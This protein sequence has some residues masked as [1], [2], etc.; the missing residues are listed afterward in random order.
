MILE[1][2]EGNNDGS[3][4]PE[5]SFAS[6]ET[7]L[8]GDVPAIA[9]KEE[10]VPVAP[11]E[12]KRPISLLNDR[13]SEEL[14]HSHLFPTGQFGC[15]VK[16]D[17]NLSASIYFNQPLLNYSQKFAG[18]SDYIFFAHAVLQRIQ[19]N[20]QINIAMRKMSSDALTA[21]ILSRNFKETLRQ[22]IANDK[23]YNFVKGTPVYWKRFMHEVMVMVEQLGVPTF[24]CTL[25][26]AGLRWNMF[27]AISKVNGIDISED[28]INGMSY[29]D[30][31]KL[32]NGNPVIV[33]RHFQYRV[34]LFFKM[35]VL[36]GPL[37][38][39]IMQ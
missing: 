27:Y 23:T 4:E 31:C 12:G 25:S 3:K 30:K 17:I 38:K 6:N 11:G 26:C 21:G 36:D 28:E 5:I 37:G 18:D 34:E 33:A 16:C 10:A 29:S 39:T 13:F 14:S 32:L 20:S 2:N 15:N 8:M 9:D 1:E 22:F 24:S 7:V 35:I 19:L